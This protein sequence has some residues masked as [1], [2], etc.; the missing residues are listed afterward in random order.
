MLCGVLVLISQCNEIQADTG[1]FEIPDSPIQLE[2]ELVTSRYFDVI[3]RKAAL[4]GFEGGKMEAWIYPF[5]IA[6]NIGLQFRRSDFPEPIDAEDL[7][8]WIVVRPESTSITYSHDEFRV[9]ATF[10]VPLEELAIVMLLDVDTVKPLTISVSFTP[11]LEPMWPASLGGQYAVWSAEN[12]AFIVSESRRLYNALIG[13]PAASTHF[14]APAHRLAEIPNRFDISLEPEQAESGFIPVVIAGG[15]FGRD[16]ALDKYSEIL[17][18]LEALYGQRIEHARKLR[19]DYLSI[20]SPD[21]QFN[22]AFEWGKVSLDDGFACNPDLGCGLVAGFAMSGRSER[23]GFAWYFGGDTFYNSFSIVGYGD[24][25]TARAGL[26]MIRRNQRED[27]K[28]MHELS[29]GAAFIRWFE[30]YPY[31]YYHMETAPYYIV[32]VMNYVTASG[33]LEFLRETWPSM[34]RAFHYAKTIISEEDGLPDSRKGGLGALEVGVLLKDLKTDIYVAGLWVESMKRMLAAA[35]ILGDEK[36]EEEITPLLEK[37]ENSLRELYFIPDKGYH[38]LALATDGAAVSELTVW[39]AVPMMFGLLP[40]EEALATLRQLAG[41]EIA[42]D[43][44]VRM[45]TNESAVYNPVAYNN[46]AVWP[47]LTGYAAMGQYKYF[48]A[49]AG[50]QLIQA[51]SKLTFEDSRG[52]IAELYSGDFKRSLD[53][54]VPHQLFS[55]GGF[56][57]PTIRGMLGLFPN[58]LDRVL[59]FSP[60]LPAEWESLKI[61]NISLGAG[62]AGM[63]FTREKNLLRYRFDGGLEGWRLKFRPAFPLGTKIRDVKVGGQPHPFNLESRRSALVLDIEPALRSDLE[64]EVE[65]EKMNWLVLPEA[66]AI[67]GRRTTGIR[68]IDAQETDGKTVYTLCGRAGQTYHCRLLTEKGERDFSVSFPLDPERDFIEVR[69]EVRD[70]EVTVKGILDSE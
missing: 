21:E 14:S 6:H 19:E 12:S 53:P 39:P 10:F 2:G 66:Q 34:L 30:D 42:T 51:V 35:E 61:N 25:P 8:R 64:I 49:Q 45:L 57:A 26:E 68:F 56:M 22:L 33:D 67:A 47:F 44:G 9:V 27:G 32:A 41:P 23:P 16:E 62:K 36:V 11:D 17:G 63:Q 5:K 29:Q 37:A 1:K 40:E 20:E 54:A 3:G 59:L 24:Y 69:V 58:G 70:G 4:M 48:R 7:A 65:L 18:N 60:Q 50:W 13:S 52:D 43:W 46:G 38:A 28:I 31:G 55:T 15:K